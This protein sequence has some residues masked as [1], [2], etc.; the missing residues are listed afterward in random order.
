MADG[1]EGTIVKP[2]SGGGIWRTYDLARQG[3]V[4][5][6]FVFGDDGELRQIAGRAL[7]EI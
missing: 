5:V 6:Y 7:T 2:S 3:D 4:S 1:R